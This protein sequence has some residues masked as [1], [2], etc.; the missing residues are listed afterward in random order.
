MRLRGWAFDPKRLAAHQPDDR[1]LIDRWAA[2][3][4]WRSFN[5]ADR[6]HVVVGSVLLFHLAD[7]LGSMMPVG[8]HRQRKEEAELWRS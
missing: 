3:L 7:L 6:R 4:H 5:W 1:S 8:E 2:W